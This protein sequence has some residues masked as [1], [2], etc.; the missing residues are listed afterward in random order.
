MLIVSSLIADHT[1]GLP[2]I[3]L[4]FLKKGKR[5]II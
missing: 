3:L 2:D 1:D 4:E 5:N